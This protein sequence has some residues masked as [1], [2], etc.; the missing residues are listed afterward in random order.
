MKRRAV[1]EYLQ[2][3]NQSYF[4]RII[5]LTG[6]R[7]SGKETIVRHCF[8]DY[9]YLSVENPAQHEKYQMMTTAQWRECYPLTIVDDVQKLPQ[10]IDQ[11]QSTTEL[12]LEPKYILLTS[13]KL[14][15]K[16]QILLSKRNTIIE[17]FPL[18]LPELATTSAEDTIYA[19]FFQ[20]Y[21]K[22]AKDVDALP[23]SLTADLR[24]VKKME[25]FQ[26]YLQYGGYPALTAENMN[27]KKRRKWL[28]AYVKTF[29]E[30]DIRD[31]VSLRHLTPFIKTQQY[32]AHNTDS[33]MNYSF[34]S[35]EADVSVPTAQRYVRHLEDCFQL[36]L[37]PPWVANSSKKLVKS[38]KIHF[39]DHGVLQ[40]VLQKQGSLAKNELK[41]A[42]VSEI[43]KQIKNSQLPVSC[44]HLST[45]D[46]RTIDVLLETPKY[47]IAIVVKMADRVNHTDARHLID[48][49]RIL[50]KP[51]K[52]S[53]VLSN[54]PQTRDLGDN[55][56][57]T[58]VATFLG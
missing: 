27:D 21:M 34:I 29:L 43:Y 17:V 38:P 9:T 51:L 45:L 57:A 58:H 3:R 40:T 23:A 52:Q 20:R 24:H 50:D 16:E 11:I 49:Q 12:F 13:G 36:I 46:G 8:P 1:Q 41:S 32:L 22:G 31:F 26:F 39:L 44:Y 15:S 7:S 35:K 25:A 19:S 53:F 55:I 4:G 18:T 30:Q 14:S 6:A 48:L 5:L 54:D 2:G 37:L 28:D 10:I 42:I 56:V 47:Y 33:I